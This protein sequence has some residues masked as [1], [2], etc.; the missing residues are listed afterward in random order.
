MQN[1]DLEELG[2]L[3]DMEHGLSG[4]VSSESSMCLM[5]R[6][7]ELN[8]DETLEKLELKGMECGLKCNHG[9]RGAHCLEVAFH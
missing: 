9:D 8:G 7:L 4:S 3:N 2:E 6:L 5:A 1:R